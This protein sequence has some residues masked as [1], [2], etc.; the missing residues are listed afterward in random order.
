MGILE[1]FVVPHPPILVH[2]VGHGEGRGAQATLEAYHTVAQRIAELAPELLIISTSHGELYRDALSI[3]TGASA[4]GD[5]AQFRDPGDRLEVALDEDFISALIAEAEHE[6]LPFVA[7]PEPGNQLDHG[8]M[9]PL[10]F[11]TQQ[12]H[13]PFRVARI[14]ISF[15]DEQTHYRMGQCVARA[16]E[17][18]G[19]RAVFVAS[20]DLS[21]RLKED[22]P[23]GFNPA[24]PRFDQAATVAFST[25]DL[26]A[27]LHFDARLCEDAAECGLNSF[28]IMAGALDGHAVE[29][30]LLSYEDPWGVG[31][32]VA[33]FAPLS[34]GDGAGTEGDGAGTAPSPCPSLPVRLAFAALDDWLTGESTPGETTPQVV[35]LL[36]T[37]S[38]QDREVLEAL[39]SRCA[40]VFVSFHK[41]KDLRGCIGTI[42]ATRGDIFEEICHNTVS[43]AAHDPRFTAIRAG[44]REE[45]SCSVDVL[46]P[47]EPVDDVATLDAKRYGVI[48]SRG[49]RRG[50]LLP[51]LE[52]VNS[53]AE[54]IDIALQKAGIAPH[55]HYKLER[56]EVVRYE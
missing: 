41:G 34:Q 10:H 4:W 3:S 21:H 6:G 49:F 42:V 32:G 17:T 18:T 24:G 50:L 38:A 39:H 2:G 52:G 15:L 16:V 27:L 33:R 1:A 47:A 11:I 37:L 20:G 36:T 54:Q 51:N 12:L 31:Y 14:G 23:Y 45:L 26:G 44:E 19:R 28:I 55:E 43:A 48:V 25:G 5:F 22:G 29:P 9:V 56:F 40:G 35:S 30:E 46:G 13:T 8:C 7:T 53:P